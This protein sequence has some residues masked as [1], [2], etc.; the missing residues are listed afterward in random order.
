[1]EDPVETPHE[2]APQIGET[3]YL[4]G[5]LPALE[6]LDARLVRAIA[7]A[8]TLYGAEAAHD[9]YR[10]L[11]VGPKEFDHLMAREPGVPLFSDLDLAGS[12]GQSS[13]IADSDTGLEVE[14][15]KD[16]DSHLAWLEDVFELTPFD[17][18]ILVVALAPELDRR[19]ERIYAFLQDHVSRRYPSVDLCLNLLCT[20]AV[21]RIERRAHFDPDA[22]LMRHGLVHILPEPNQ[23]NPTLLAHYVKTDEQ[24][25]RFLLHQDGP[26]SRLAACSEWVLPAV[27][28]DELPLHAALRQSFSTLVRSAWD[29]DV[30]VRLYFQG[31]R[32]AG[33]RRIAEALA[34]EVDAPLLTVNLARMLASKSDVEPTNFRHMVRMAF[35]LAWF[36]D[37]ILFLDG[38]DTLRNDENRLQYDRLLEVLAASTGITILAGD[39]AWEPP[40]TEP[41][42]I[43]VVRLGVPEFAERRACWE[44]ELADLGMAPEA[45]DLDTLAGRFRL[46]PIQIADAVATGFSHAMWQGLDQPS[47]QELL[48]AARAQTGHELGTLASKIEPI[49]TWDDIELPQDSLD[50][51]REIC[52]RVAHRQRVLHEWQFDRKLSLGKG[53]NVLFAGASGTGKTMAAEVL[54]NAL[55]LDLYKIDLSGVVSKYI[56]ETEKNLD[57][58]FSAAENANAILLFDEAD[59]LFGKRSEVRDSHDRYANIE[60]S[61]LLQKMEEYDGI[62]IL[63][64]NMRQNLD[65]AFVRRMAFNVHFPFPD[66]GGRLRIWRGIWPDES[67]LANDV[68][69]GYLAH[70]FRLS[71][72]NIRNVALA[73]AFLAADTPEATKGAIAMSHVLQAIRREYQKMGK[74]LSLNE[75][76]HF[77]A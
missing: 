12:P 66:E 42:G 46:L 61:Y 30:P 35:R 64:T 59:A 20:D 1:M 57:R 72:G 26:D 41:L 19:Y 49:Y 63:S 53:T 43:L 2:Q 10:G 11:Y 22:P 60:I 8:S 16:E 7:L 13:S 65:D 28:L 45:T 56:G 73:A 58:I 34:N 27:V 74:T 75:L 29:A 36:H 47:L 24:I 40:V 54:A 71:G 37:A 21:D 67:L 76:R 50:Q 39:D 52:A 69:L 48:A 6:R 32:G 4:D 15:T 17:V 31:K 18:D 44:A 23:E 3:S 14:W 70:A 25:V 33:Q 55:G 51:L 5:I 77:E 68:D 38:L 9:L 62:T